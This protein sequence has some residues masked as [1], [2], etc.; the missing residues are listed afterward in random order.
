[1]RRLKVFQL[2]DTVSN[3]DAITEKLPSDAMRRWMTKCQNLSDGHQGAEFE[4]FITQEWAYATSVVS[5][6]TSPEQALKTLGVGSGS[7]GGGGGNTKF[8]NWWSQW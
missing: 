3:I 6:V 7:G 5:R 1:V 2:F 4:R 8:Q